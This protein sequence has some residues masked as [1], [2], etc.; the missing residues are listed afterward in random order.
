MEEAKHGLR[1]KRII[2]CYG[3]QDKSVSR[4]HWGGDR[5][6]LR[7]ILAFFSRVFYIIDGVPGGLSKGPSYK[8]DKG[9][10]CA[11]CRGKNSKP[12]VLSYVRPGVI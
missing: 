11:G 8:W 6:H 5:E 10:L 1:Q 2:R 12:A 7:L 9:G 3:F 4:S